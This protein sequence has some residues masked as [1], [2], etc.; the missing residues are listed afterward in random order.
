MEKKERPLKSFFWVVSPLAFSIVARRGKFKQL[1]KVLF[2]ANPVLSTP[3]IM[4]KGN[5]CLKA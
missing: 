3:F 1:E 4:M 2:L 5:V